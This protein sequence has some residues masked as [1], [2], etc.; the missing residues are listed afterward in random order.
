MTP[1]ADGDLRTMILTP[2]AM[3]V[4][5]N[6]LIESR[7]KLTLQEQRLVLLLISKIRRE[8]VDFQWYEINI[9]ELAKFIGI[10][11][12]KNVYEHVRQSIKRLMR[13]VITIDEIN[14]DL[15][16]ID[17]A[18]Y[19]ERGVVRIAVHE[20]LKPYLLSL[21]ANFTKYYLKH[22]IHLK[23]VYSI[24]LYEILKR[25]ENVGEAVFM[26]N[27]L[28]EMLG[29]DA[30]EYEI[31]N[32]FKRKTLMIA[33]KEIP[34]KTDLS[35]DFEEIKDNKKVV[36]IRF[37]IC[38]QAQP[39]LNVSVDPED[40]IVGSEIRTR[41]NPFLQL[42]KPEEIK[43]AAQSREAAVEEDFL[44]LLDLVPSQYRALK[45][46]HRTIRRHLL[47][48]GF[49]YVARNI[50][51]TNAKSNAVKPGATPGKDANYGVYLAKSLAGDFGLPFQENEDIKRAE[52]A[53]AEQRRLVF[54]TRRREEQAA[55]E[56]AQA[57]AMIAD[58]ILKTLSEKEID[59]L[60]HEAIQR[61]PE[62]LRHQ[63][64]ASVL[65]K[66]E[67]RKLVLEKHKGDPE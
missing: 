41:K 43:K 47:E 50:N 57:K 44:R 65:V 39:D 67:L 40:V 1:P 63:T 2:N 4:K 30:G 24:R 51:Y 23:S 31:Y 42:P 11:R 17:A 49:A 62:N 37:V 34:A 22:V 27:D 3:V 14:T 5:A 10:E 29:V 13:R 28:K 16:W 26:L 8:H 52:R 60:R 33:H 46:I 66:I 53:L 48:S 35:F 25:Y 55:S 59:D 12:N 56:K 21:K 54:E 6:K 20:M 58:D 15:H 45:S 7:Y 9:L 18:S 64:Y 61:I 32:N 38:P 19:S 36:K